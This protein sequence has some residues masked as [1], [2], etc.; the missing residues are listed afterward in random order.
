VETLAARRD[1]MLGRF[2]DLAL[3]LAEQLHADAMAAETP[4]ER[5]EIA[6][7]FHVMGRTLR[8]TFALHE[9]LTRAAEETARAAQACAASEHAARIHRKKLQVGAPLE[10]A[11]WDEHE[12]DDSAEQAIRRLDELLDDAALLDGFLDEPVEQIIRRLAKALGYEV[13]ITHGATPAVP[14]VLATADS[15]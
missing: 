11:I 3:Q 12:D 6:R 5:A 9:R 1:Q 10:R 8:Q 13:E 15:S 4:A 2:A 7:A 14:P